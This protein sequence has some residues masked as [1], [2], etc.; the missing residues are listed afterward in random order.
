[1]ATPSYACPD[2]DAPQHPCVVGT[3]DQGRGPAG[4][5]GRFAPHECTGRGE[6]AKIR[7]RAAR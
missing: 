6:Y 3:G 4:H 5:T 2:R 7:G 1:M